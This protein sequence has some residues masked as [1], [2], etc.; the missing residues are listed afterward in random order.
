M[1]PKRKR[2]GGEKKSS[3]GSPT[4]LD[5]LVRFVT[6][7]LRRVGKVAK[8]HETQKVVKRLKQQNAQHAELLLVME[9]DDSSSS[10][11]AERMIRKSSKKIDSLERKLLHIKQFEMDV[12]LKLCMKRLGLKL[13]GVDLDR[14][15]A[16]AHRQ[17]PPRSSSICTSSNDNTCC[18]DNSTSANQDSKDATATYKCRKNSDNINEELVETLLLHKTLSIAM[19]MLNKRITEYRKDLLRAAGEDIPPERIVYRR[20]KKKLQQQ[21]QSSSQ[22]WSNKKRQHHEGPGSMF[23]DSLSGEVDNSYSSRYGPADVEP[24]YEKKNR[25]GQR[26]R[27]AK[28]MIQ[29]AKKEGKNWNTSVNWRPKKATIKTEEE[30]VTQEKEPVHKKKKIE[31]AEVADMG[32]DWKAEGKAHPSW[33]AKQHVQK[34]SIA[35]FMGKKITF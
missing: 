25:P 35:P 33:A 18:G 14:A 7:T 1:N 23:L 10:S 24:Y 4:D 26:A 5:R 9:S 2:G 11:A 30:E 22:Q 20:D 32:K 21:Q 28:A 34:S 3:E 6:K 13:L 31:A 29:Q 8:A 15:A 27:Q 16:E 19:D 12:L 17:Q